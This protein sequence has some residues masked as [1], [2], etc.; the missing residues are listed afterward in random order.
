MDS[1]HPHFNPGRHTIHWLEKQGYLHSQT[2][3]QYLILFHLILFILEP[4]EG[5]WILAGWYRSLPFLLTSGYGQHIHAL[6]ISHSAYFIDPP[7]H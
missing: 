4:V 7:S 6:C 5:Y 3:A 1:G 2:D